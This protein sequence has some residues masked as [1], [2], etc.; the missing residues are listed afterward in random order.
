VFIAE[1]RCE[2]GPAFHI[3]DGGCGVVEP[4]APT[5]EVA[6][7]VSEHLPASCSTL[8][9]V[10]RAIRLAVR[11][12]NSDNS[13]LFSH[14]VLRAVTISGSAYSLHAL[15]IRSPAECELAFR[16]HR[17]YRCDVVFVLIC[18]FS[19]DGSRGLTYRVQL[20]A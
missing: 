16:S 10:A 5:S 6:R 12:E 1:P 3:G 20:L 7:L 15:L 4:L 8:R 14:V 2:S 9:L 19:V 17:H 13:M 11:M 18:V